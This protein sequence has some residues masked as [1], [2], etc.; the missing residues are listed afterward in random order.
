MNSVSFGPLDAS[1]WNWAEKK[2]FDL[3]L[4]PSLVPS[5]ILMK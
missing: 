3:C 2:G 5:F 4:I 1:G